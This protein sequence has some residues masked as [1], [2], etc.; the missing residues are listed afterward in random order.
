MKIISKDLI[1]NILSYLNYEDFEK[2]NTQMIIHHFLLNNENE[3][4]QLLEYLSK[5]FFKNKNNYS[6]NENHFYKSL[7]S[8]KNFK[9]KQFSNQT[10]TLN[11]IPNAGS[12]KHFQKD[13]SQMILCG[14]S[15]GNIMEYKKNSNGVYKQSRKLNYHYGE[16]TDVSV[17]SKTILSSSKDGGI[18]IWSL[19]EK[20]KPIISFYEHTDWVKNVCRFDEENFCSISRDRTIRYWNMNSKKQINLIDKVSSFSIEKITSIT[21]T[22]LIGDEYGNLK[23][24]YPNSNYLFEMNK[25]HDDLINNIKV[26]ENTNLVATSSYDKS[27]KV[28]DF[29]KME[30]PVLV[31][32]N[33]TLV[34]SFDY[35]QNEISVCNI[36]GNLT[37]YS[38]LT[39]KKKLEFISDKLI[40]T[41]SNPMRRN[42]KVEYYNEYLFCNNSVI[43]SEV[44]VYH[45]H[46]PTYSSIGHVYNEDLVPNY[47]DDFIFSNNCLVSMCKGKKNFISIFSYDQ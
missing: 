32:E 29:R 21:P 12:L 19:G 1:F 38:L 26:I 16:I 45:H 8:Y 33:N 10:I 47:V 27:V 11:S 24:Y 35:H 13:D 3:K 7:K 23:L 30:A 18:N 2:I 44:L 17:S 39:G 46:K 28:W 42:C 37:S 41:N 43:P 36:S 34:T 22:F 9:S 4:N 14:L 40:Y 31:L 25:K 6:Q 5:Q 20:E 15:N